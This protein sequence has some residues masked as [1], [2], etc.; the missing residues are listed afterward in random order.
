MNGEA[1]NPTA[2][3][4]IHLQYSIHYNWPPGRDSFSGLHISG[5]IPDLRAKILVKETPEGAAYTLTELADGPHSAA[6]IN[7]V[8]GE[9]AANGSYLFGR[10]FSVEVYDSDGSVLGKTN[11]DA[12]ERRPAQATGA[13][14]VVQEYLV[15]FTLKDE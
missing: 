15:D 6:E 1:T 5:N 3:E 8:L 13:S 4:A 2:G 7:K 12:A 9:G 11:I 10:V 14:S